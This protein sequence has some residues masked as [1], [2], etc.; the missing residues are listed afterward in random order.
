MHVITSV[1]FA[2]LF[3]LNVKLL[4]LSLSLRG[5]VN[6]CVCVCVHVH[7]DRVRNGVNLGVVG[8]GLS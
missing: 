8:W 7:V 6:I 3:T 1:L 2:V 4:P 5:M